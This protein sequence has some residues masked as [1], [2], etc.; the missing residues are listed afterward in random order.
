[1]K[2]YR[3]FFLLAIGAFLFSGCTLGRG[4]SAK[5]VNV[6]TPYGGSIFSLP[7]IGAFYTHTV[8]PLD[9]NVNQTPVGSMESASD[10]K[11]FSYYVDFLWDTN[12]IGDIAEKGG[13]ETIYYADLEMLRIL[14]IW[15]QYKIHIYGK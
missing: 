7:V 1:M 12:A 11:V 5:P 15:S 4:F 3:I 8:Q 2:H 14:G 13:I 10:I 6:P 9:V